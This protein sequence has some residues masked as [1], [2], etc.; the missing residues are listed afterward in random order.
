MKMEAPQ[1]QP[2]MQTFYLPSPQATCVPI[3][4]GGLGS[5]KGTRDE[6]KPRMDEGT[7]SSSGRQPVVRR[8]LATA[9]LE[10]VGF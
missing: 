8:P 9:A 4:L 7:R 10:A 2:W 3:T 5:S 1:G 6:T